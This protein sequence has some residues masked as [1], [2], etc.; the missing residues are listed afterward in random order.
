Y[1]IIDNVLLRRNYDS[2]L[3][4]RL[5]KAEAQT[6]LQELHDGPTGDILEETLQRTKYYMLDIIGQLCSKM[7]MTM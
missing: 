7:P 6:V 5:E 4:I 3:L 1:E 2:V